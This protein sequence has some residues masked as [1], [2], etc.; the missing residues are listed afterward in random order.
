MKFLVRRTLSAAA[1]LLILP[2]VQYARHGSWEAATVF[3]TLLIGCLAADMVV[4]QGYLIKKQLAFSTYL[5][6]DKEWNS[7]QMLKARQA[8][9][10]PRSQDWNIS[11]LEAI[12]EFFE[13]LASL[14]KLS[15]DLP[16]IYEST[17]GWYAA[18]YFFYANEHHQIAHLRELWQ[19][20]I[21]QDVES[22]FNSYVR[23][24][25]GKS[26]KAQEDWKRSRRAVEEKFWQQERKD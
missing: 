2:L 17:L 19:S 9:H 5:D 3:A 21:Y 15:G 6:L 1:V 8:V 12:L 25:I 20:E 18:Q 26:E 22:F 4:W 16:F 11:R 14:F 24:V 10:A 13:K 7:E 23:N